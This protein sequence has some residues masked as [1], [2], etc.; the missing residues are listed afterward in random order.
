MHW[1]KRW[2]RLLMWNLAGA[3]IALLLAFLYYDITE[4]ESRRGEIAQ[5][6]ADGHPAERRPP[7]TLR[8]LLLTEHR[9]DLTV[10]VTRILLNDLQVPWVT[11]GQLGWAF[12][13]LLWHRLVRLHLS[14]E[15]QLAVLC[16]RSF[17]GRRSYGYETAA[18]RYFQRPLDRL[19]QQ[20][21]ALLVVLSRWPSHWERV[22]H[23]DGILRARDAL[24]AGAKGF[25][26]PKD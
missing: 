1:L 15:E 4:F 21:L 16:S 26:T 22:D 20:E 19:T 11:H 3:A 2:F 17:L 6:I 23:R 8:R 14:Q 12:T 25:L 5:L 18:Q 24:M 10:S 9:G 7:G 13:R